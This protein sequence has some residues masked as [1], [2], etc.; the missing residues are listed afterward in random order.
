MLLFSLLLVVIVPALL[1]IGN[2]LSASSEPKKFTSPVVAAFDCSRSSLTSAL[3]E[4]S[5]QPR[6]LN[7]C[8]AISGNIGVGIFP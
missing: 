6:I 4:R 1:W 2:Q 7:F 5:Q 3:V 8:F